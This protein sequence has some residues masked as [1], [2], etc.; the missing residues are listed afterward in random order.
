MRTSFASPTFVGWAGIAFVFSAACGDD[1]AGSGG[2]SSASTTIA[3]GAAQSAATGA[4]NASSSSGASEG[5]GGS[6]P[7]GDPLFVAVGYGGRRMSSPDGVT[8]SNDVIVDVNGGDDDNLFRGVGFVGGKFV[9]VGGSSA[10]QIALSADGATWEFQTPGTSWLA[11]VVELGGTLVTAGGNGL[12][13][14]S[15][16]G[17]VVWT[18]QAPY[19]AG[20]YRGIAAGNGVAVAAGHTYDTDPPQGLSSTTTDGITWTA[21]EKG[22]AAFGSIAFGAGRF[23]AAGDNRCAVSANGQGW[24]DC[25]GVSG[26][27]LDH[28]V[29]VNGQFVIG[30]ASGY[31]ESSD[32]L[33]WQHVDGDH[34][35][36]SA[37]GNG[38]YVALGWPDHIYTSP[39]LV[40]WTE[41]THEPGPAFVE[42]AFGHVV[43]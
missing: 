36:V 26:G 17:G 34:R 11:D 3:T 16:D 12:K 1:T 9:A 7:V 24:S 37:H 19:L 8:W 4:T 30:N 32:G 18:D 40:T 29:F 15:T 27:G 25:N 31:F 39:D 35:S 22:G 2:A 23:V 14:R 33:A 42:V 13:Q 5:G 43:H 21:E 20:H 41:Q 38:L 10:G 28:V 6:A